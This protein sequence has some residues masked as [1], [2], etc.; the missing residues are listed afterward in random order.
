MGFHP[1]DSIY[2]N[3]FISI[4]HEI[5][6]YFDE[7]Y[8]VKGVFVSISRAFDKLSQECLLYKL[9]QNA[10]LSLIRKT[11][12]SQNGCFK[13]NKAR[14]VFRKKNISYLLIRTRTCEYQGVRKV[15]FSE[16]LAGFVFFKH[17]F[18]DSS[19]CLITDDI[20]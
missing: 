3:Q 16:N 1:G 5:N 9:K 18:W 2:I 19:F 8:Q 7:G 6:K 11:G 13:K 20:R 15:L 4:T 17:R 10:L 12:E 14:Q